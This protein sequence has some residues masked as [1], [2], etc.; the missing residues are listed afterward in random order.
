MQHDGGGGGWRWWSSLPGLLG[1][2]WLQY[3]DCLPSKKTK[4]GNELGK[5]SELLAAVDGR[6]STNG[7]LCSAAFLNQHVWCIMCSITNWCSYARAT[8]MLPTQKTRPHKTNPLHCLIRWCIVRLCGTENSLVFQ[9]NET[10]IVHLP[11]AFGKFYLR[12]KILSVWIF[13]VWHVNVNK[14]YENL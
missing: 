10:F 5:H 4:S 3:D 1:W 13:A 6:R 9:F 11:V 2:Q 12:Q 7:L 14:M 8:C